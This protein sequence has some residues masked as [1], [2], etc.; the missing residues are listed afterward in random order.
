MQVILM[1]DG[2]LRRKGKEMNENGMNNMKEAF[3][4]LYSKKNE[5]KMFFNHYLFEKVNIDISDFVDDKEQ[6]E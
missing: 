4:V 6:E 3:K 2:R 5:M 1:L